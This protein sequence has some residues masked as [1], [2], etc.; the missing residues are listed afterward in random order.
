MNQ[1][2]I[3]F[4]NIE[5]IEL[6]YKSAQL[7]SKTLGE[8]AK[9]IKPGITTLEYDKIAEEFIRDHGGIPAFLGLYNFPNT[10][11]TS[12]NEQVVHGIPNKKP[13][14]DGDILSID[15]GVLL[16]GFYSD[17]AYTFEIGEST[18]K[19]IKNM[20]KITKESLYKGI[21][22]CK[23][24]NHIGDIGYTIQN[25]C[26][27]YGYSV[28]RELVGHALGKQ[29]HEYPMIPNY[30]KQ[31]SGEEIHNGM[32]LAIEPM[33]N[34]GRHHVIFHQDGWTVSSKDKS[35]SCHF[36]HNIAILNNKPVLL[37]TFKYIYDALGIYSEEEIDF[38]Y[39]KV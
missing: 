3:Y 33:T 38:K 20:L 30:G 26:E 37:S 25:Y 1:P 15:C 39:I 14:Q 10:L 17:Q 2:K 21:K 18:K 8:I 35:Y 28:V 13:L 12:P 36:E 5:E 19:E 7:T 22:I 4:K 24:G 6:M 16:N 29:I 34:Y 11:C 31:G 23:A 9:F 27:K 32:T